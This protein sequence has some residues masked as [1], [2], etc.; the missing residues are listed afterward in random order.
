MAL[1]GQPI[2]SGPG[3]ATELPD[4]T[5]RQGET[6][7]VEAPVTVRLAKTPFTITDRAGASQVLTLTVGQRMPAPLEFAVG[8][9]RYTLY[10]FL[11]PD[12]T[13]LAPGQVAVYRGP[14]VTPRR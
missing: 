4:F 8:G 1:Y 6:T 7:Y 9:S 12:G 14:A 13:R 3:T 11:L 10:T 5:L 2:E